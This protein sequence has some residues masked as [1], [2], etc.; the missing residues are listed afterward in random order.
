MRRSCI[1]LGLVAGV[2]LTIAPKPAAADRGV[3]HTECVYI[4]TEYYPNGTDCRKTKKICYNACD[5]FDGEPKPRR[6]HRDLA[7]LIFSQRECLRPDLLSVEMAGRTRPTDPPHPV[8]LEDPP[9]LGREA[10]GSLHLRARVLN[11]LC[12][13]HFPLARVRAGRFALAGGVKKSPTSML[14]APA[15]RD[16]V[17]TVGSCR[18][19][20]IRA[21]D[22]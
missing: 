16:S 15:S 8:T 11:L 19:V 12:V 22:A 6:L 4:C 3:W 18:P 9:R 13:H 10:R 2:L 1:L 20:S 14:R 5:N 17:P 7:L 21:M